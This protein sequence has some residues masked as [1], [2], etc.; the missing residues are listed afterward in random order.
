MSLDVT[1]YMMIDVGVEEKERIELYEANI[2]HNMN[3]MAM[4]ADVYEALWYPEEIGAKQAKDIIEVLE[5]GLISM[6]DKP[7]YYKQYNPSNGWGS[8]DV[9]VVW[10]EDYL[11][12]CKRYPDAIIEVSR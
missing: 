6:K 1:L 7:D 2:T 12:A 11:Y 5:Q 4:H 3:V 8:Y 9:F 10:V